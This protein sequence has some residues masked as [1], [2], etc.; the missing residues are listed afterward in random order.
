M[1][2]A[3]AVYANAT[4]GLINLPVFNGLGRGGREEGR[5]GGRGEQRSVKNCT[6]V[7][8]RLFFQYSEYDLYGAHK[9]MV[10]HA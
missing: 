6:P 10:T 8:F 4:L 3:K 7:C 9:T 5:E 1:V 2:Q